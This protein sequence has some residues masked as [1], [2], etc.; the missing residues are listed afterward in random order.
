M[1]PTSSNERLGTARGGVSL[2]RDVFA[3]GN[4]QIPRKMYLAYFL[5]NAFGAG[6]VVIFCIF[7]LLFFYVLANLLDY[8]VFTTRRLDG[9]VAISG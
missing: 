6:V 5:R 7:N 3:A 9:I 4:N 8:S 1:S 2:A